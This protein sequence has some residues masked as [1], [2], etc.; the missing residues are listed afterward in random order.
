MS[1]LKF[2]TSHSLIG[3]CDYDITALMSSLLCVTLVWAPSWPAIPLGPR[4]SYTIH[5][6][7]SCT[8]PLQRVAAGR[9]IPTNLQFTLFPFTCPCLTLIPQP[10]WPQPLHHPLPLAGETVSGRLP[11]WFI[12]RLKH[13]YTSWTVRSLCE[14]HRPQGPQAFAC[15]TQTA[16]PVQACSP[17]VPLN[18]LLLGHSFSPS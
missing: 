3:T 13:M 8:A 7:L 17:K 16:S 1:S 6:P 10:L 11:P 18:R 5:H 2:C 12:L 15:L 9:A 4:F 14:F